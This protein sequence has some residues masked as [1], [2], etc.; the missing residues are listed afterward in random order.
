M[1][2]EAGPKDS[3]KPFSGRKRSPDANKII[4]VGFPATVTTK[5]L[6][7]MCEPFG[8]VTRAE[9]AIDKETGRSRG[10]GFVSF[11][12]PAARELAVEKLNRTTM[13]GRTLNVR[14]C[15]E[16][17]K[18]AR[19]AK[20]QGRPCFNFA[21][22]KCKNGDS[23]KFLHDDAT[24]VSTKPSKPSPNAQV[25]E[26]VCVKFQVGK[27]HRGKACRWKHEIAE[28]STQLPRVAKQMP[29]P[30]VDIDEHAYTAAQAAHSSD[31]DGDE[32]EPVR[33]ACERT[34]SSS[35]P[36]KKRTKSPEGAPR[37]SKKARTIDDTPANTATA[38]KLKAK[39]KQKPLQDELIEV[40]MQP[41]KFEKVGRTPEGAPRP[42]QAKR[43]MDDTPA[44]TATAVKKLKPKKKPLQDELIEVPMQPVKF[45]KVGAIMMRKKKRVRSAGQL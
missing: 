30:S 6:Q 21:R 27:C 36:H 1:S 18:Q 7:D 35:T 19:P 45:E 28:D 5:Q 10:F 33:T 23:C 15:E 43:A 12:S 39:K 42:K 37:F 13:E 11:S 38:V 14:P 34:S 25:P 24:V 41:V 9:L 29:G 31:E 3:K 40:P 22:G 26:G 32:D 16:R 20:A 2:A 44:N 8:H 17:G 4:V